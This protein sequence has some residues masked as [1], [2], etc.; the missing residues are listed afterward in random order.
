MERSMHSEVTSHPG[1]T[2]PDV[3]TFGGALG[4]RPGA[5]GGQPLDSPVTLRRSRARHFLSPL[6]DMADSSPTNASDLQR[7][8]RWLS[9]TLGG[10]VPAPV[11]AYSPA[12]RAGNLLFVSGQVPRDPRTGELGA[13]DI[14]GQT[15]QVLHNLE[16]VLRAAGA[17]LADVVS[18]IVYLADE[19][20]WGAFNDVY[21]TVFQPPYPSRTAV[22]AGLRGILVEVSAIALAPEVPR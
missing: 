12:V 3:R 14:A 10:D 16:Q 21:R 9:V 8:R 20:D 11:G 13:D 18:V 15:R 1:H 5:R 19:N 2:R 22:G 7:E 17:S 6:L 4:S